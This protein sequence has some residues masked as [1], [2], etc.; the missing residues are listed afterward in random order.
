MENKINIYYKS[1]HA[2]LMCKMFYEE[3]IIKHIRSKLHH[4]AVVRL[5]PKDKQNILVLF[6]CIG[7]VCAATFQS[8]RIIS[9]SL[10]A[11]CLGN[12]N[13]NNLKQNQIIASPQ[14]KCEY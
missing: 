9:Q 2:G 4:Q 11:V 10:I 12:N 6:S 13:T 14:L 7:F 5:S 3:I 8:H 1:K